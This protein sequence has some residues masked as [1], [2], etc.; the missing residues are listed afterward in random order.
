M[1]TTTSPAPR[2]LCVVFA[3]LLPLISSGALE[4]D[5]VAPT[6]EH[7]AGC[8]WCQQELARYVAVDDALRLRFGAPSYEDALPFPFDMADDDEDYAFILEDSMMNGEQDDKPTV[9]Y[10][11][12]RWNTRR[13]G[14][15]SRATAIAGIAAALILAVVATTIYTQFA[16]HRTSHP[17]ATATTNGAFSK[18]IKLPNPIAN[19]RFITA[20]R[21]GSVW[22]TE[23]IAHGN[24]IGHVSLDGTLTEF[25]V[26]SADKAIN[27]EAFDIT[28]GPDGNL[29]SAFSNGFAGSKYITSI[30]RV[31]P[32]GA[33]TA[34]VLPNNVSARLL[35]FGQDGA[36]WF[37]EGNKLGRMTT[38]GHFTEYPVPV[39]ESAPRNGEMVDL[40]VGPAGAL[41]YTWYGANY[42]GRMTLS[43]QAKNFPIPYTGLQIISGPD[44]ALWYTEAESPALGQSIG[45]LRPGVFGHITTEGVVTE[46]P[47][48]T[49][50]APLIFI[51]GLEGALWFTLFEPG[52]QTMRLARTAAGGQVTIYSTP[53]FPLTSAVAAAPGL[54]WLLDGTTNTLWRFR[55]PK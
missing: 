41:W 9:T 6:R 18:V 17:A 40:C 38:D 42:I 39:P 55:L 37:S 8:D 2:P 24:K 45:A 50:L 34:F 10:L 4:P 21:D 52:D 11:S 32:D 31:T 1:T 35:H 48:E 5:E 15:T 13:H 3:P 19:V 7:V 36:L 29:W 25:S 23:F 12:P 26:P 27:S 30:I 22:F 33:M 46:A 54:I 43:G 53:Q 16:T 47:I 49:N 20:G 44:G 51:P 14:L 28:L